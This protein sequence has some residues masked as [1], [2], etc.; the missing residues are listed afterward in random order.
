MILVTNAR[1]LSIT[2]SVRIVTIITKTKIQAN[3]FGTF[4]ATDSSYKH[5][6]ASY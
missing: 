2:K 1:T 6:W 5:T 4:R 3:I